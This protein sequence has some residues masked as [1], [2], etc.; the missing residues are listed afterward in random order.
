MRAILGWSVDVCVFSPP[1][2]WIWVSPGTFVGLW[3]ARV[4]LWV[5]D[6]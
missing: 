5:V 4:Q 3:L 1:V 6:G 2:A